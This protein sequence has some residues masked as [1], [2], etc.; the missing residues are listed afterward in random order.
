MVDWSEEAVDR[1]RLVDRF[2]GVPAARTPSCAV[3]YP[4]SFSTSGIRLF[5]FAGLFSGSGD[6]LP[7]WT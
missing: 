5:S 6:H 3:S 7:S 1:G 2:S 4:L